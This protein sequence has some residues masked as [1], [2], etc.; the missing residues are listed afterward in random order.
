MAREVF[1][2]RDGKLVPKGEAA[3]LNRGPY[4]ISDC[5]APVR[6]MADGKM[7]DSKSTYSRAVRAAGCEIVGNEKIERRPEPLP[8]IAPDISRA[9]DQL[10]SR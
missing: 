7:Y 8:P 10:S 6:S 1:V 5:M 3:P 4:V 2:Y 9:I